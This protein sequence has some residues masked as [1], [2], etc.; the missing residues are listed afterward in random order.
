MAI[1]ARK[2]K[3]YSLIHHS[4]RGTR[5]AYS[6]Y[7]EVLAAYKITPSM[8]RIGNPYD[9]AK[10]ERFMRTLK[11]EQVD[12][13]LYRDLRH[14][15]ADIGHFIE[16]VH[17]S[18]RLHTALDYRTPIR[19]EELHRARLQRRTEKAASAAPGGAAK[20]GKPTLA[21][22]NQTSGA[23]TRTGRGRRCA[24]AG[25]SCRPRPMSPLPTST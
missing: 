12:G 6:E 19:F 21:A 2:P 5:Y 10:V 18:Q 20:S 11:Q 3:P 4:D 7:R 13:T 23:V 24:K 9:N 14:A 17:N 25:A 22:N 1:A 15:R 8:S 16:R